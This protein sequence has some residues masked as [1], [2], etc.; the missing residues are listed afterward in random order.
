VGRLDWHDRLLGYTDRR[1]PPILWYFVH[2]GQRYGRGYFVGYD[3]DTK[4]CVGYICQNGFRPDPPPDD[5]CFPV[6][7]RRLG[8]RDSHGAVSHH[9]YLGGH[10]PYWYSGSP[11]P[12]PGVIPSST[13]H[14]ITGDRLVAVDL[15]ERTVKEVLDA[16]GLVSVSIG[17]RA[18]AKLPPLD[19]PEGFSRASQSL[20]VRMKDRVV[21]L[22]ALT[23]ER[24]EHRIPSP[25]LARSWGFL[26]LADGT[27]LA[28]VTDPVVQ[29]SYGV[30]IWW[31]EPSGEVLRREDLQLRSSVRRQ[32]P[33]EMA[34]YLAVELPAPI[35][36]I[37]ASTVFRPL[38]LVAS[39]RASSYGDALAMTWSF[40]WIAVVLTSLLGVAVA[41]FCNRRQRAHGAPWTGVWLV[42]VFLM[43]VPG[44]VAYL[45]Y[46]SW[47]ARLACPS[48]G[49][50][51]P[52]DRPTCLA[53][54]NHFPDPATKGIEVFA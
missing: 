13:V 24:R 10:E 2:T 3:S 29:E 35:A 37:V 18:L 54:G 15:H 4:S 20:L 44:L 34:W 38:Q 43:G 26:E 23:N 11:R 1:E 42:F 27:A 47:A 32:S 8:F 14:L 52:R 31:F 5:D 12:T 16:P 9:R 46:R 41:W 21:A 45:T 28:V 36:T 19:K 48:C 49:E 50:P 25:L 40:A 39:G 51:A 53:C 22:D 7:A 6:D 33:A 30:S 17:Q